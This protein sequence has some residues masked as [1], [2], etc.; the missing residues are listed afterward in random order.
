MQVS[1]A[2]WTS[3]RDSVMGLPISRVIELA[4]RLLVGA[5]QLAHG[6]DRLA[7]DRGGDARPVG[8]RGAGPTR[9]PWPWPRRR[10]ARRWPRP[11]RGGPGWGSR[12]CGTSAPVQGWPSMRLVIV[13]GVAPGRGGVGRSGRIAAGGGLDGSVQGIHGVGR[14]RPRGRSGRGGSAG[15]AR[16]TRAS[17]RARRGPGGARTSSRIAAR[18]QVDGAHQP[19][20][21]GVVEAAVPVL[22]GPRG[23]RAGRRRA[24]RRGR[25][26]RRAR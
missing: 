2:S 11:R 3:P 1:M 6:V 26:G 4:Q 9:R 14:G 25:S 18:G 20:A 10:P 22:R 12:R 17:S 19:A 15:S 23:V 24:R 8:L 7:P 5:E 13:M 16:R 21:A